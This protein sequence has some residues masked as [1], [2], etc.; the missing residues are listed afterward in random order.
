MGTSCVP[1]YLSAGA[2]TWENLDLAELRDRG[3]K[4]GDPLDD[5][6]RMV[7]ASLEVQKYLASSSRIPTDG[8][9]ACEMQRRR[10]K[11]LI[12]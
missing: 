10:F 3:T 5:V 7:A 2:C 6:A 1:L 11:A 4:P 8:S 12:S 9:S